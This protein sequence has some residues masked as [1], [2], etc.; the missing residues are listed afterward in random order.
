MLARRSEL[1]LE[2]EVGFTKLYS[3]MDEGAYADL[4]ALHREVDVAVADCYSWPPSVAQ[5]DAEIVSR[6]TEL[7]R[8]IVEGERTCT[9][10]H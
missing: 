8:Q 3:A 7:N 9:P 4:V 6:L 10:F 1:C 5:D 2:H